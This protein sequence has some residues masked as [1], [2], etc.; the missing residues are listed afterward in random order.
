MLSLTAPS[1]IMERPQHG[2][3]STWQ[4]LLFWETTLN[5]DEWPTNTWG[6]PPSTDTRSPQGQACM[7]SELCMPRQEGMPIRE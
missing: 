5:C 1:Q 4:L 6:V 2:R 3:Q 7:S